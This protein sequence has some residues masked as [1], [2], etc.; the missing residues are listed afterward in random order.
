MT[1]LEY[2]KSI[3]ADKAILEQFE[4]SKDMTDYAKIVENIIAKY[5]FMKGFEPV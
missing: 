2:S 5:E 3:L 1:N 4:R